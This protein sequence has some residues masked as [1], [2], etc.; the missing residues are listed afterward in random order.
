MKNILDNGNEFLKK[1]VI[2]RFF[3]KYR[4]FRHMKFNLSVTRNI[5]IDIKKSTKFLYF[6]SRFYILLKN[7]F[8]FFSKIFILLAQNS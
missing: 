6:T 5:T 3:V 1:T 4:F 2:F 8:S 7:D